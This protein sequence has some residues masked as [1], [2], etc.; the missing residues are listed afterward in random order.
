MYEAH[1]ALYRDP[2]TNETR[3]DRGKQPRWLATQI[4]AGK[5]PEDFLVEG[6]NA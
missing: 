1:T 5:K 3:T 2:Q 6:A 4:A